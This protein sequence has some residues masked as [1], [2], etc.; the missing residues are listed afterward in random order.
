MQEEENSI[1][2]GQ[3]PASAA[4]GGGALGTVPRQP[5][6]AAGLPALTPPLEGATQGQPQNVPGTVAQSPTI[7]VLVLPVPTTDLAG[8]VGQSGILP[9][10]NVGITSGTI[11]AAPG[12]G[13]L[14][15]SLTSL[16]PHAQQ[17][18]AEGGDFRGGLHVGRPSAEGSGPLSETNSVEGGSPGRVLVVAVVNPTNTEHDIPGPATTEQSGEITDVTP[19]IKGPPLGLPRLK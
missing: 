8:K 10:E 5:S 14:L 3:S 1:K 12:P 17:T 4:P 7:P 18:N 15:T 19:G 2:Q 9:Q 11:G 13:G 6:P 16:T